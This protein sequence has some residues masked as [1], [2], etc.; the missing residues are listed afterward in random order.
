MHLMHVLMHHG[1][2][3]SAA[4]R[5]CEGPEGLGSTNRSLVQL[6][7][8]MAAAVHDYEHEGVTNNFL[9]KTH[10][11]KA[12]RYNDRRA[13]EEHHVAAACATLIRP[14]CHFVRDMPL[15]DFRQLRSLVI[16]LVVH[17]DMEEHDKTLAHFT[18]ILDD[19]AHEDRAACSEAK[20]DQKRFVPK[21]PVEARSLL[22]VALKCADLGHLTMEWEEHKKWV[23][24][25]EAEFFAQ[26]DREKELG[27][28]VSFL[29]DRSLPGASATQIGFMDKMVL[30]LFRALVRA[31]PA[32]V[33]VL[34]AVAA[35]Y[36][37][38]VEVL[39]ERGDHK[40]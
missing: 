2:V 15:G 29:M 12:Y 3:A 30:P 7:G 13:N 40:P 16:D 37:R 18:K 9:V 6:A 10:H 21:T 14:E 5:A 19:A 1:G 8:L 23:H 27:L 26:G 31:I 33:P 39:D 36:E 20:D 32:T 17:T 24:C 25:L 11:E 34:E 22:R 35:N 38:W 28:P 4:A